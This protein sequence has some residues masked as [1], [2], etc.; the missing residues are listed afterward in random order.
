MHKVLYVSMETKQFEVIFT[1]A[2]RL[3]I[4]EIENFFAR[5]NTDSK[6]AKVRVRVDLTQTQKVIAGL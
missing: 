1:E 5:I 2:F 4:L 6:F 3:L